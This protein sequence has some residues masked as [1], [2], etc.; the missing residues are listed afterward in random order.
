MLDSFFENILFYKYRSILN[1]DFT[2]CD[3]EVM[4]V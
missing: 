2:A 3:G 4:I 1:S